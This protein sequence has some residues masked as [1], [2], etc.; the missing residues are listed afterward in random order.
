MGYQQPGELICQID[1]GRTE[2]LNR[3]IKAKKAKGAY[4]VGRVRGGKGRYANQ[5]YFT[6]YRANVEDGGVA[7][8]R[9]P[10]D[11]GCELWVNRWR[12]QD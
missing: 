4:T 6:D 7:A 5:V 3:E 9:S 11:R 10:R 8:G 1:E 12:L 2:G